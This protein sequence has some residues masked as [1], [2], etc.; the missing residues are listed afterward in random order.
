LPSNKEL[1]IIT[2]HSIAYST[3]NYSKL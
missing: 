1:T 2:K 3:K